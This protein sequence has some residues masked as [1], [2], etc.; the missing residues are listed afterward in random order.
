MDILNKVKNDR[1]AEKTAGMGRHVCGILRA[2]ER[3]PDNRTDCTFPG[4]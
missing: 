1:E 4:V 3:K 2:G